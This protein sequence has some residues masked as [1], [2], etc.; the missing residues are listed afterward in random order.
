MLAARIKCVD[1]DLRARERS[2]SSLTAIDARTLTT[3]KDSRR[4][5]EVGYGLV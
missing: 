4:T 5:G 2:S 1:C 3:N